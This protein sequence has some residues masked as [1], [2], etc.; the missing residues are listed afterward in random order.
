MT[1]L[2]DLWWRLVSFGF[3]LLY[4]ELSFT[5]DLVSWIVSLG[6]WRDWQ[7]CA[8][9]HLPVPEAGTVLELAHGTGHLQVDLRR[10]NYAAIGL[11]ASPWMGRRAH[12]TMRRA[13]MQ[14]DLFQAQAQQLPLPA[15]SLAAVLSTFP[16]DFIVYEATLREVYRTLKPGGVLVIVPSAELRTLKPGGVLVIVPSAELTGHGLLARFLEWL[17]RVTGQ[18]DGNVQHFADRIVA[19]GFDVAVVPHVL[20]R[21]RAEV[22]VAHRRGI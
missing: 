14:A 13:G 6:A 11:D 16:T 12:A 20:Q 15:A 1:R 19:H 9:E 2:A 21:S 10:R 7:R 4:G 22:I 5:Y 18:R 17:Y 3:C 8:L